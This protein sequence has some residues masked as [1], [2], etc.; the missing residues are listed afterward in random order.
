M[1]ITVSSPGSPGTT[2]TD[3]VKEQ[4]LIY[5]DI[6]NNIE[7]EVTSTN[8]KEEIEKK[9]LNWNYAR[10]ILAFL[11]HCGIIS[12]QDGTKKGSIVNFTN[13]GHT[14]IDILKTIKVT[15]NEPEG[16]LK[17]EILTKLEKIQEIIFFQCLVIMMKKKDCNYSRDF[18]DVLCFAKNYGSIDQCEYFLIQAKRKTN[19]SFYIEEMKETIQQYRAGIIKI[20]VTQKTKNDSKG[21]VN[22]FPYVK[23][24][25]VKAGIFIERDDKQI[26][27]NEERITEVNDA[28]KEI[29]Q[30]LNSAKLQ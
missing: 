29:E 11:K 3:N 14:Y 25:F 30:C 20:N 18:F 27:F 21:N 6:I 4:I 17:K 13:I 7:G 22:S 15:N 26:C 23:G 5:F 1:D 12:Y 8:I 2:L 9:Q 10:N 19:N 24:N 28:I 16:E